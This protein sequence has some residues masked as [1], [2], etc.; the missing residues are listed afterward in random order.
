VV[1]YDCEIWSL[2][3]R[4][5]HKLRVFGNRVLRRIFGPMRAEATGG[6]RKLHNEELRNVYSSSSIIRV[7]SRRSEAAGACSANVGEEE[8]LSVICKKA[9]GKRP[10]GDQDVDGWK[11][12]RWILKK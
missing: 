6:W 4:E 11:P 7:N 5:D 10:L 12:L 2:I 9:E 8:H 1:L 3:L